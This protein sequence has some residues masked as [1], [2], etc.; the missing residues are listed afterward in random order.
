MS[1]LHEA[2]NVVKYRQFFN[3]LFLRVVVVHSHLV[4]VL[5]TLVQVFWPQKLQL[6][7]QFVSF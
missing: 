2:V 3:L 4:S 6:L 5:E 1:E 7:F